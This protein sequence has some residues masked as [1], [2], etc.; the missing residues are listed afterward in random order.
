MGAHHL[1]RDG[2]K[3][4][5]SVE[6]ILEEYD[7]QRFPGLK[8]KTYKTEQKGTAKEDTGRVLAQSTQMPDKTTSPSPLAGVRRELPEGCSREAEQVYALVEE[9]PVSFE[10]IASGCPLEISQIQSAL[11]ELEIYG[12]IR[13]NPG[14]RFS[15]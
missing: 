1:I 7:F 2:A 10:S 6:D 14:R 9:A 4:T 12:L 15:L 11:T 13:G 8:P 5:Q 3:L